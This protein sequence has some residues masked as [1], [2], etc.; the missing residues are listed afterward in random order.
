M[1]VIENIIKREQDLAAKSIQSQALK[2]IFSEIRKI[3][4][5]QTRIVLI[6]AILAVMVLSSFL[7]IDNLVFQKDT[8]VLKSKF[9]TEDLKGDVMNTEKYWNLVEGQP[10]YVNIVNSDKFS[11]EKIEIIMNTILSKD[12]IVIEKSGISYLYYTGWMGALEHVEEKQTLHN[13]PM[14][15]K[16]IDS[17][18]ELGD[19]IIHLST[20]KDEDGN[21]GFTKLIIEDE[22]ILRTHI[23]IFDVDELSDEEL[24]IISRHEFRHALGLS[25]STDPLDLMH[26]T[27]KTA[28]P[29]ISEC[30]LDALYSLYNNDNTKEVICKK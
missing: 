28:I 21:P 20:L 8:S 10:L 17:T 14:N 29:Y 19:I 11:Q 30:N 9:F 13:L 2:S 5:Q 24:S 3:Q 25:H 4:K 23:T 1:K 16:L 26:Q 7:L 18:D 12:Q 22:N 27:I 15:L 6:F